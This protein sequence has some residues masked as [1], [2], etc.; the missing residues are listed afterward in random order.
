M[1]Q[2]RDDRQ[3]TTGGLTK[4]EQ[5]RSRNTPVPP[6]RPR[7]TRTTRAVAAAPKRAK[8]A[9]VRTASHPV[10]SLGAGR[11]AITRRRANPE[12]VIAIELVV[13]VAV[14]VVVQLK[15]GKAPEPRRIAGFLAVYAILGIGTMISP[16]VGRLSYLLGA[17]VLLGVLMQPVAEKVAPGSTAKAKTALQTALAGLKTSM[18]VGG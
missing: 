4:D 11:R 5:P 8:R 13:V 16:S 12:K 2:D 7:P 1:A 17:L 3:S 18:T 9:T 10:Q 6:R 14:Y 15:D